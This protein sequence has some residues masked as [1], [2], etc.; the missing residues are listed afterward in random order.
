M[1]LLAHR[2][3][4]QFSCFQ[5]CRFVS[6]SLW[7]EISN[8]HT[9]TKAKVSFSCPPSSFSFRRMTSLTEA[10]VCT[11]E[12]LRV[13]FSFSQT[14]TFEVNSGVS[15]STLW[16]MSEEAFHGVFCFAFHWEWWCARGVVIRQRFFL[17][18]SCCKTSYYFSIALLHRCKH[19]EER[20]MNETSLP[21][22]ALGKTLKVLSSIDFGIA[23]FR[24]CCYRRVDYFEWNGKL[25]EFP[26]R[27]FWSIAHPSFA[28]MPVSCKC[29]KCTSSGNTWSFICP[30]F[31]SV[32][33]LGQVLFVNVFLNLCDVVVDLADHGVGSLTQA[34]LADRSEN[35]VYW[36]IH[37][38]GCDW[39]QNNLLFRFKF[40]S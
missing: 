16:K 14:S 15:F 19:F 25:C 38:K 36:K 1:H 8:E 31:F 22:G 18:R 6:S 33:K 30:V 9:R 29:S 4:F 12:T 13:S 40:V 2:K 20:A 5:F 39:S 24:C 32:G 26:T 21:V 27:F 17:W 11:L 35:C 10:L 28:M 3:S 37:F 23:F 7:I 34:R